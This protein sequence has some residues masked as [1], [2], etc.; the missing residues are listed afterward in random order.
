MSKADE[1]RK[2]KR[3]TL[4]VFSL[5]A[6][7]LMVL[8]FLL[9]FGSNSNIVRISVFS[10]IIKENLKIIIDNFLLKINNFIEFIFG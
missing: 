3:S 10:N 1:I 5:F 7:F 6:F 2:N 9:L 4:I 8:V